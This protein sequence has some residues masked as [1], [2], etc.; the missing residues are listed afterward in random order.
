MILMILNHLWQSTLCL[1]MAAAL[2]WLLRDNG[3]AV[4]YRIWLAASVKFLVPFALLIWLGHEWVPARV[5]TLESGGPPVGLFAQQLVA[6]FAAASPPVRASMIEWPSAGEWAALVWALGVLLVAGRW[7]LRWRRLHRLVRDAR[8][9]TLA[10]A[11]PVRVTAARQEPGLVG[12]LNPVLLVPEQ[13]VASLSGEELDS[14]V[15]HELAHLRRRDNLTFAVHMLSALVFWFYPPI[16]WLGR[17]LLLER[18]RACDEAV[19]TAGHDAQVYGESILKV[20]RFCLPGSHGWSAAAA[21]SDLRTRMSAILNGPSAIRL[22]LAKRALLIAAL[23]FAVLVPLLFGSV[24]TPA[25]AVQG[26]TASASVT[27]Q[28]IIQQRYEQARPRTAIPLKPQDFDKFVG[29]YLVPDVDQVLHVYRQDDHFFMKGSLG[30]APVEIYP[31]HPTEFFAKVAPVQLSFNLASGGKVTGLVVH[32]GGLL[33]TL[34]R[35][36]ARKADE[37]HAQLQERVKRDQPSPGTAAAARDL[38]ETQE[39]GH[40]D[41]RKMVPN[42]AAVAQLQQSTM[43]RMFAVLGPLRSLEFKKVAPTGLDVYQATFAHGTMQVMI[44]P[45]TA[46]DR[47]ASFA[48][49]PPGL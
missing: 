37:V 30:V 25:A 47:V 5:T 3:A 16:W 40:P 38:I 24:S 33:T 17:R 42:L 39:A 2:T 20:C 4:R 1:G 11:A 41:Y 23:S 12:I 10:A 15:A 34:S 26:A 29:Y 35:I 36:S 7:W 32:S 8:P 28:Q 6:P 43:Q 22:T 49:V 44:S 14:I 9:L 46:D 19:L 13:L 48:I 18:E 21:G 27:P 31:D 45:L